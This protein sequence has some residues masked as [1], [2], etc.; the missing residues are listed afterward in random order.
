MAY[1]HARN[2]RCSGG[3]AKSS[4]SAAPNW[5]G[6]LHAGEI[7][8]LKEDRV[9]FSWLRF[10]GRLLRWHCVR[11]QSPYLP[12]RLQQGLTTAQR[13]TSMH[14]TPN[15]MPD[16]TTVTAIIAIIGIVRAS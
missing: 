6:R 14:V 4:A 8:G 2:R 15:I 16:G 3:R 13:G 10:A 7:G 5:C 11:R 9:W 1:S 12:L